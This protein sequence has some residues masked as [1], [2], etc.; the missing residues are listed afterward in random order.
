VHFLPI[1]GR[2]ADARQAIELAPLLNFLHFLHFPLPLPLGCI[3][4]SIPPD[5]TQ[6][7]GVTGSRAGA[8]WA[9]GRMNDAWSD[10]RSH[11]IE[12]HRACQ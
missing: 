3:P 2:P 9:Y 6:P 7:D 1:F 4:K 11:S 5:R 8:V 12:N 10:R